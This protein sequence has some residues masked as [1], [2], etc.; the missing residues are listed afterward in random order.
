MNCLPELRSTQPHPDLSECST[1]DL[2]T[3]L[4]DERQCLLAWLSRWL[5]SHDEAEDV[6]QEA[7]IA[8]WQNESRLASPDSKRA[9]LRRAAH[10]AAVDALRRRGARIRREQE[11]ASLRI[12]D[13]AP[14]DVSKDPIETLA[15]AMSALP[16]PTLSLLVTVH[17][18]GT[19]VA[20]VARREGSTANSVRVRLHRARRRL[21][22]A[23]RSESTPDLGR[24]GNRRSD[25]TRTVSKTKFPTAV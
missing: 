3:L 11:W 17:L 14:P 4:R 9:W 10:N 22:Q 25:G 21:R 6:V 7:M 16:R 13:S 19:S 8:V 20:E 23:L 12:P 24:T 2:L 1:P 18:N 15:A 5:G